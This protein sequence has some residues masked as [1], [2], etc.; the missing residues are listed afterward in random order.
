MNLFFTD[1]WIPEMSGWQVAEKIKVLDGKAP[2]SIIKDWNVELQEFEM[3]E[4]SGDL[5]IKKPFK[6]DQLLNLVQEG[7]LLRNR[8]KAV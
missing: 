6:I 1:L 5:L 4:K 3:K 7:I 2:I 8:F